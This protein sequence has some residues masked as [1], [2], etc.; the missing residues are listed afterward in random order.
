M[1]RLFWPPLLP[2][3][4][5]AHQ[6]LCNVQYFTASTATDNGNPYANGDNDNDGATDAMDVDGAD[7]NGHGN[8]NGHNGSLAPERD[9]ACRWPPLL[10]RM[11]A[12]GAAAQGA[13]MAALGGII[14][15]LQVG[16]HAPAPTCLDARTPYYTLLANAH[17][18]SPSH[19]PGSLDNAALPLGRF[20]ELPPKPHARPLN[21]QQASIHALLPHINWRPSWTRRCCR[22]ADVHCLQARRLNTHSLLIHTPSFHAPNR[23]RSWTRGCCH[24]A[25]SRSCPP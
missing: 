13:A 17:A 7:A 16:W 22:S 5:A 10:R 2:L 12:G 25:A 18:P 23:R 6:T 1:T 15:F 3:F 9:P 11:L 4:T 19:T 14:V 24:W 8:G 20:K 21:T